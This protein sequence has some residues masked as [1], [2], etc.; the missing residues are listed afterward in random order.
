MYYFIGIFFKGLI[1]FGF[2]QI[3]DYIIGKFLEMGI[4]EICFV[5]CVMFDLDKVVFVCLEKFGNVI[6]VI[7]WDLLGNQVLKEVKY[8]VFV[9][10]NDYVNFLKFFYNDWY[11]VLGF[12]NLFDNYVEFVVFDMN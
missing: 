8:D 4:E 3:W 11:C 12:N 10:N 9:G 7:V 2:F 6:Y 5:L 1:N